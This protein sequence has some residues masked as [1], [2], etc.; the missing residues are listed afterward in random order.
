MNPLSVL[1]R[2]LIPAILICF[3]WLPVAQAEAVKT[4]SLIP[5][6]VNA[7]TPLDSIQRGMA[8]M[9]YSRLS[10]RDRVMV[11]PPL[12][13]G[14]IW[15]QTQEMPSKERIQN[16]ARKTGSDYVILGSITELAGAFSIDARVIDIKNNRYGSFFQF[17]DKEEDLIDKVDR[18]AAEIN[19]KVFN[20]STYTWE[21]MEAEKEAERLRLKRQNPE[22]L[23]KKSVPKQGQEGNSVW[24][25]WDRLF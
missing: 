5:F 1:C 2:V 20:R 15:A 7:Q 12:E 9:L 22:Y 23:L 3:L 14:T 11:I 24:K 18:L 19:Q 8:Q 13:T 6:T 25:I 16:L 17:S 4:L 10:W 21:T